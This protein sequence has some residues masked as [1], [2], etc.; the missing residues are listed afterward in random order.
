MNATP[1]ETDPRLDYPATGRNREAILDVLERVLP[2]TGTVLEI[3]SGSGQHISYF[4]GNLSDL[5]WQPSDPDQGVF[6]SIEAWA[7]H[8]GVSNR[9]NSPLNIDASSDIWPVGRVTD[10][11]SILSINMI[12]I[13]P[14]PACLGLLKNAARILKPDG[15]L[16][17]YG[18]YK[19]GGKHT[20]ASNGD[21][22]RSLQQQNPDWGVRNLDDV[23]A[24]ALQEG[25]Q[26]AETV[27]MPANNLSVVFK[28]KA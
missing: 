4:A 9:V 19:V 6:S 1:P 10:I 16:Y 25:F 23:A 3:A 13:A 14:W 7:D 5:K 26:L 21:F 22:D 8:E 20:A 27:R 11:T 2:T 18:P 28:R 12:H 17:L 15:V 24:I